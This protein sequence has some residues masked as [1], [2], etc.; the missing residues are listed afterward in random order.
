MHRTI[1]LSLAAAAA[2]LLAPRLAEAGCP[3]SFD[4]GCDMATLPTVDG[5]PSCLAITFHENTC[6]CDTTMNVTNNC[7]E[8]VEAVGFAWC[9]FSYSGECPTTIAPGATGE[10]FLPRPGADAL[11]EHEVALATRVGATDTALTLRYEMV[12]VQIG[13]CSAGGG[14]ALAFAPLL[15]AGVAL[16]RRRR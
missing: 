15:L 12:N 14:G 16:R 8:P 11:G 9:R 6:V 5:A 2:C 1:L 3:S 10:L 7:A 13:G 4:G